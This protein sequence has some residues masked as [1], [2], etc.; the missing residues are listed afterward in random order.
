LRVRPAP[1]ITFTSGAYVLII[2]KQEEVL[3]TARELLPFVSKKRDEFQT[4]VDYLE[5][6]ITGTDVFQRFK[7]LQDLGIR[8]KNRYP[9]NGE[10]NIPY[11]RSEGHIL[12]KSAGGRPRILNVVQIQEIQHARNVLGR[13]LKYL[14][15]EF[16]V[17]PSTVK[18]AL[19]IDATTIHDE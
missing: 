3:K 9:S 17:S 11:R 10:I 4:I 5:D 12:G 18:S 14:A 8:E 1:K 7:V 13:T 2:G 16:G 19:S 15:V 6:R